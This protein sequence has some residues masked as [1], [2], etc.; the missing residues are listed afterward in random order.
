MAEVELIMPKM[1]ESVAEATIIKWLKAEGD[2]IEAEES[3][4]E[5]ATDKVDSEI[6]SPEDG[7]VKKLLFNEDDVVQVGQVIAIIETEGTANTS[8]SNPSAIAEIK[9]EQ[10]TIN[11][12]TTSPI[13][14]SG[15]KLDKNAIGGKFLSPLVRSIAEAEGITAA[16]IETINGKLIYYAG[17][18]WKEA[19][20]F[21]SKK[22]WETYLEVTSIKI[23][24][25]LQVTIH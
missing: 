20:E 6:P 2:K 13:A 12:N 10:P 1:G 25:P 4:I 14:A 22:D 11:N 8:A 23:N 5:I 15:E 19:K 3:I 18:G 16:E 21:T 9:V 17:F 24:N 7:I